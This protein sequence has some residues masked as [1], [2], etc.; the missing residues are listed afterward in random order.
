[1]TPQLSEALRA[2]IRTALEADGKPFDV[3]VA[4]RVYDLAIAARDMCVAATTGVKEAIDQIKDTNG[5]MET[6]DSPDTPESQ[7]QASETFGARLVREIMA[8]LPKL[9]QRSGEDPKALVRAIAEARQ[10]GL[11]DV[12]TELE[13]KLFGRPIRSEAIELAKLTEHYL[14]PT[15][16]IEPVPVELP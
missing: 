16:P 8:M 6:L 2:E 11:H 1:M 12:A 15:P 10:A 13:V 14:G 7:M 9:N 3:N 5:P 4:R